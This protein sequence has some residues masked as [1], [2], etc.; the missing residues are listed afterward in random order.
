MVHKHYPKFR[1]PTLPS[2]ALYER[3]VDKGRLANTANVLA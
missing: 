3:D 1:N 2:S